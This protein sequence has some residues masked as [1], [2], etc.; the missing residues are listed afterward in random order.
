MKTIKVIKIDVEQKDIY[1]LEIEPTL[2]AFYST[3][4]NGCNTIECPVHFRSETSEFDDAL[5]CDE[6]ARIMGQDY[7]KG[8]FYF[9]NWMYPIANNAIILGTD[10]EGEDR[11]HNQDLESLKA[12]ITFVDFVRAL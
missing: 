10:E 5:Y 2:D 12:Q 6:N 3:I 1:E 8:G 11:S 7:I 4:G 9:P